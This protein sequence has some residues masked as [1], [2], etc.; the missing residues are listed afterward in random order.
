[1]Q[2]TW[3]YLHLSPMRVSSDLGMLASTQSIHTAQRGRSS[4]KG[5]K[6]Q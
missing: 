5:L 6:T 1:M 4:E 3:G 2:V